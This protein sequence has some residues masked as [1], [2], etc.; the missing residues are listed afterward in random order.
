MN[1]I[2]LYN[3]I[4]TGDVALVKVRKL[5]INPQSWISNIIS[6]EL[7]K[8]AERIG[9]N[10][11]AAIYTHVVDFVKQDDGIYVSESIAGGVHYKHLFNE[12]TFEDIEKRFLFKTP[13]KPYTEEEKE[14]F[15]II[16]KYDGYI[17]RG[18]DFY[19]LLHQAYY[20]RSGKWIGRNE[21]ESRKRPYCSELHAQHSN[22]VRPNTYKNT[23]NINPY[24]VYMNGNFKDKQ[25]KNL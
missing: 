5:T 19:G 2:D 14:L 10:P 11:E 8:Y 25:I 17:N 15:A 22:F 9:Q 6:S 21:K 23:Y 24:D 12:Y 4:E 1:T 3:S 18:Y 7:N 16:C 13:V 20:V